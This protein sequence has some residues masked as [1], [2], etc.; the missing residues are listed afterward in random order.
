[1]L[2][3][4]QKIDVLINLSIELSRIKDLDILMEY[5]LSEARRFANADAGSIYIRKGDRLIFSYTQNATLQQKLPHGS[6]LI[7]ST[8]TIPIDQGSIAGFCAATGNVLN[9]PDAACMD[10]SL[11]YCFN[12]EFDEKSGYRTGSMLTIPLKTPQGDIIG[13]LQIINSQ[14]A[15]NRIIPFS[16]KDERMML[17]FASAATVA[18]ERAQLTRNIILRTIR[19]TEMRDPKETGTHANRVASFATEIY[20]KWAQNNKVPRQQIDSNRDVLRMAAMLHDAGKVAISDTILRKPG[21]FTPDEYEQMKSHALAGARIF[22]DRRS[23]FDAAAFDVSLNHHERWDGL[24]YP[25][26]V[27]IAT[28]MPLE[29]KT[30]PAGNPLGKKGDEIP[31]FGRIV[32]IADIF[33]ALTAKRIYKEAWDESKALKVMGEQSGRQFDPELI[34]VFFSCLDTLRQIQGRYP[35]NTL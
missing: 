29:G 32:A 24:G 10:S 2:T 20:E 8:F 34:T 26:H 13:V 11:P 23:E 15:E 17:H 18:L 21:K 3:E 9:I 35:E 5:I 12:P 30:D 7:Y 28:G 16:K 6:K 1:M 33:D 14:D 25:G 4:D 22:I 31:L 27:D 19:M